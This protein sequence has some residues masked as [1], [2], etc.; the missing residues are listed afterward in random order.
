[1][2]ELPEVE[3]VCNSLSQEIR[4]SSRLEGVQLF[5]KDLRFN[6]PAQE[7]QSLIGSELLKIERRGKYILFIFAK[8]VLASHLGMTGNWRVN[9]EEPAPIKH[10][11]VQLLFSS[12]QWLTYSDPRRFGYLEFL[13]GAAELAEHPLFVHL[14]VEPLA[15]EFNAG[16]LWAKGK[17]ANRSVKVFLMDQSIVVG[18]GNIYVSEA[19]FFAEVNP[20]R[21]AKSLK[22]DEWE[23]IV[24][25]IKKVL[26]QAIKAGGSS[27][28]DY[29]NSKGEEGSFQKQHR[30]YGKKDQ[31]CSICG[32]P[33]KSAVIVG[34]STFW[35][36]RCQK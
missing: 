6:I 30:V 31:S 9:Q 25:A 2:P 12:H 32:T 20:T 36:P 5:R 8:G 21:K 14:G 17:N 28:R 13:S 1:M 24:K 3:N 34:R 10:D 35:C 15:K 4:S 33:I 18:V 29:R 19:L 11:H 22:K 27:I 7:M 26:K 16:Y 23:K